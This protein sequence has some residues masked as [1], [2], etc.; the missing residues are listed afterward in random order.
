MR[1]SP[2]PAKALILVALGAIPGALL[3][4]WLANTLLANTLACLVV[5]T[6]GLLGR[7]SPRRTLLVGIG[8][9]GSLSTFSTWV[10][11]LLVPLQQGHWG[12]L[13]G[14]ILRDGLLGFAAL[15]IGA[16]LHRRLGGLW[17]HRPRR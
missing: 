10:R 11:E 6:S 1:P 5:G 7:P 12:A 13:V 17:D 4:W 9:A 2:G 16:T 14:Q 3:R 15:L 8:F